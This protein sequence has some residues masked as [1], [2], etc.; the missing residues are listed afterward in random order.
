MLLVNLKK[1]MKLINYLIGNSNRNKLFLILADCLI[2]TFSFFISLIISF[3]KNYYYFENFS[4]KDFLMLI[5]FNL[6][7]SLIF[8]NFTHQ[9]K[10]LTRFTNAKILTKISLRNLFISLIFSISI[11]ILK[12]IQ[13]NILNLFCLWFFSTSLMFYFRYAIKFFLWLITVKENVKKSKIA[14]YG[15]G[16]AANMLASMLYMDKSNEIICF[17]DDNEKLWGRTLF[18]KK[19]YS[20]KL[21]NNFRGNI[22]YIVLAIMSIS[23]NQ[24]LSIE[25]KIQDLDIPLIKLPA[26]Y[27]LK[28]F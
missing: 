11:L 25:R 24:K 16:Y 12:G 18:D 19:I 10:S 28:K 2:L 13:V 22:D 23:K 15:A 3:S 17:F 4:E 21:I 7:I 6:V 27:D 14:I 26:L 9:Y 20:P 1:I 5:S 8:Y